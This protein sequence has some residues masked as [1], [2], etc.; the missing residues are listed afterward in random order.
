[1]LQDKIGK[2]LCIGG[3]CIKSWERSGEDGPSKYFEMTWD[4]L[5]DHYLLNFRLNLH[6]KSSGIPTGADLDSAFLQDPSALITKKNVL[7]V[8]CQ[9]YDPTGLAAP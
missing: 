9:F 6:K 4:R 2:I 7:S 5:K 1:M 3:F 8:A